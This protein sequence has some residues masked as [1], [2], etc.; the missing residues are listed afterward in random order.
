MLSRSKICIAIGAL[1]PVTAMAGPFSPFEARGFAMGGAGVA[2]AEYAAATLYNPALLAIKTDSNRFSFI[3]PSLGVSATGNEGAFKNAQDF[4]DSNS[5]EHFSNAASNYEDAL[6]AYRSNQSVQNGAQLTQASTNLRSTSDSLLKDLQSVN[7]KAFQVGGGGTFALAIPRWEYKAALSLS[8]EFA[9]RVTLDVAQ[10]DLNQIGTTV[11][12]IDNAT[13]EIVANGGSISG[14]NAQQVVDSQ[15]NL[16][17]NGDNVASKAHIL[18]VAVTDIGLSMARQFVIQDQSILVGITPKIQNIATVAK[19]VDID[20]NDVHVND[21]KK[22]YTGFNVDVGV[23]K[24]FEEGRLQ[25]LRVGLVV[26]NLIPHTYKTMDA[27]QEVK[28]AP[29]ARIGAAYSTNYFTV[30]S[31]LDLTS[32]KI[33][34]QGKEASQYVAFGAE[35]NAWSIAK[36]RA[37]FRNDLKSKISAVTAGVSL[38]GLQIS[39][40]Y[41]QDREAAVVM[42]FSG[43]F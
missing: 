3:A 20:T 32:N 14:P 15:G 31:D 40:A 13:Q 35:L 16:I 28:I 29:Q 34:G 18:G 10:S 36:L 30:T 19:A 9:A 26:R 4:A 37:G 2:S 24:Q 12:K 11:N 27:N 33:V 17:L 38:L 25:N 42:Q 22:T 23:A 8:T 21:T 7:Q 6:S 5:L 39:A 41:A 1:V 43:S